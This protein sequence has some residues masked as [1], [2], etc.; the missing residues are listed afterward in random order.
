MSALKALNQPTFLAPM[1]GVTD[2]TFRHLVVEH[3]RKGIGATCTEFIRVSD[4]PPKLERIANELGPK[5]PGVQMGLQL[6]GNRPDILAAS[7]EIASE[8]EA[9]FIDI[10]F[11]CPAPKVFWH[12]A[13]SALLGN[14]SLLGKIVSS[15]VSA[16]SIP[17]TAKIR[18][19]IDSDKQVEEIAKC[20]EQAGASRLSVHGRLK[21]EKYSEPAD[22]KRIQRAV[23][24]I[25]IPVIGNGSVQT[26][27][28][29]EKMRKETGCEAVM[30]GRAAIGN[31]WFFAQWKA[32]HEGE[33]QVPMPNE[34]Q[35]WAWLKNYS[36][37][38][39]DG[40]ATARHSLGKV[41]Q[42]LK[43]MVDE[44]I[45]PMKYRKD[46]LRSQS[47]EDLFAVPNR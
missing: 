25:S 44:G 4:C 1:E 33:A 15:M 35:G 7:A 29:I 6:M 46:C 26:P 34:S 10:N 21:T 13:G 14:L 12:G 11:G 42:S 31:P 23:N 2:K 47:L 36:R 39:Q 3:S 45:I 20:I 24:A 37:R 43:A 38:I 5:T 16:S 22:W 17:I 32:W 18:A 28:D 9:D 19:G 27:Q 40:G 30:V 41:K 8:S